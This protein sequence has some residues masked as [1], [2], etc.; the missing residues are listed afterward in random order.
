VVLA[1]TAVVQ[2]TLLRHSGGK[3]AAAG[4][5]TAQ[6]P[7]P[8]QVFPDALFSKLTQD[9]QQRNEVG[10]LSLVAP[11]ARPAVRL[12]WENMQAIGY[13]TGL[14]MPTVSDDRVSLDSHGD[15]SA[16]I[17]AGTHNP[18]DPVSDGK[19]D[20]PLERYQVGLHFA[21]AAA[22]G[23]IT[24]WKPVGDAPWD[25]GGQLYVRK[26]AN[27]VVAGPAADSA[28][29]DETLPIA[30]AAASYDVGLVN[31]VNSND[32]HQ[33]GFVV[34]VSGNSAV[35]GGWFSTGPQP[36]GW[37]PAFFGGLTVPLPGPGVSADS[38][39]S[40][41]GASDA[42]T[43]GARVVI[44]PFEDQGS[45]TQ[46]QETVELV[47]QFMLDI[48]AADDQPLAGGLAPA[49]VPPWSVEGLAVAV[50]DLYEGNT[51]P[52]PG[53][54]NFTPLD[55]VLKALPAGYRDGQIPTAQQLFTGPLA[56]EENWNDVVASV[57]EYIAV[58]RGINQMFAA[59][60][61][62]WTR[63]PTP[64]GNV[65]ASSSQGNFTFFTAGAIESGWKAALA[66]I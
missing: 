32:L 38:G 51:N 35:R 14:V 19:P 23:Q 11:G 29:V 30:Q 62:L 24:S 46:H 36:A 44:T 48:L 10:F 8:A 39:F 57:Y 42:A 22:T 6:A 58:K 54:Y 2:L 20:I 21:S 56:T 63:Y 53:T 4:S 13:T 34:F 55:D 1:V 52:T 12:W 9:L 25:Q 3:A 40:V 50:Q 27:V 64:F 15:G 60:S 18:L 16:T 26:A 43:G 7:L 65:L 45:A 37:P 33:L 41:G 47:H 31:N 66:K 59:A 28:V 61:L 17:L 5:A 49:S